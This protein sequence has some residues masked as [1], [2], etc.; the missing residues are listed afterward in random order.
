M[1]DFPIP[2]D[3]M[4]A[5]VRTTYAALS[6]AEALIESEAPSASVTAHQLFAYASGMTAYPN[7]DLERHLQRTPGLRATYRRMMST[8]AAFSFGTAMAASDGDLL[9]RSGEGCS[10]RFEKS[11]AED[12]SYYVI[13]E[14]HGELPGDTDRQPSRLVVCDDDDT[15]QQFALPQ[16]R[17]GII[18]ML[19]AEDAELLDLL[20][21]SSTEVFLR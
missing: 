12:A 9:P 4:M 3:T 17:R 21:K 6:A 10:I 7:A 15:C 5:Q 11:T 18:Q 13:I 16:A 19:V 2:N 1:N 20:R 8:R 14:L